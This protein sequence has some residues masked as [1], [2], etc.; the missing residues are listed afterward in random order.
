M[1][2]KCYTQTKSIILALDSLG[3][4]LSSVHLTA[5][6]DTMKLPVLCVD[7]SAAGGNAESTV[8]H[9]MD[10]AGKYWIMIGSLCS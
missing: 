10:L 4:K 8:G 3:T 1:I 2:S 5:E 9:Q 7:E 6:Y